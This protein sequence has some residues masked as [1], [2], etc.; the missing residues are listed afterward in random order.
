MGVSSIKS[1][2]PES[3]CHRA[4]DIWSGDCRR[5]G[6]REAVYCLSSDCVLGTVLGTGAT[7]V[8]KSDGSCPHGLLQGSEGKQI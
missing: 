2:R 5:K 1:R 7:A 8:Q 4:L 6:S 3:Y